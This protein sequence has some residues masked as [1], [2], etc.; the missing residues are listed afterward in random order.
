MHTRSESRR[1]AKLEPIKL[2]NF[3]ERSKAVELSRL[4]TQRLA[5]LLR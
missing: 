3:R 4:S 5:A 2:W 1:R